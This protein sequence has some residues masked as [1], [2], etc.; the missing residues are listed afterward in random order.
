MKRF[1]RVALTASVAFLGVPAVA[2]AAG[3]SLFS[4]NGNVFQNTANNPCLFDGAG[5]PCVVPANFPGPEGNTQVFA[6]N[7]LTNTIDGTE[8]SLG[9]KNAVGGAFLLGFDI[10][11]SSTPQNLSNL[12][13]S[14]F[15]GAAQIG[16]TLSYD[17]VPVAVPNNGNNGTG[18][19]DYVFAAGCQ[20][21]IIG[22]GV[23]ARCAVVTPFVVPALTDRI[24]FT[25]GMTGFNDGPDRLFAIQALGPDQQCTNCSTETPEPASMMLLGTGL[26]GLAFV[27]RRRRRTN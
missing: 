3:I 1:L 17:N 18:W 6:T 9:W 24:V 14:F 26:A 23:S 11:E 2:N 19:A 8:Y 4:V 25:F 12:T 27:V 13:I 7:P 16:S 10:N 5:N 15:N 21:T 20:G 22:T